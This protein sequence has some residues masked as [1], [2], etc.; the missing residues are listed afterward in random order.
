MGLIRDKPA[1][2]AREKHAVTPIHGEFGR[3]SVNSASAA[4]KGLDEAYVV[5]VLATEDTA[6]GKVTG[7]C[8]CKGWQVRKTCSHLTDARQGAPI[9]YALGRFGVVVATLERV[10]SV[11]GQRLI[12]RR[13]DVGVVDLAPYPV[14]AKV[15]AKLARERE[16]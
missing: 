10:E 7:T 8:G 16:A 5:D 14:F 2:K 1:E 11:T 13:E 6:Q 4:K 3:Y 9:L 15:V 12:G